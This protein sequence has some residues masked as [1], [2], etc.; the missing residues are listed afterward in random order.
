MPTVSVVI[1]NFNH[2]EFLSQALASVASLDRDD[3][4][5]IEVDDG[6]TD[7]RT[8]IELADL[9]GKGINVIRQENKGCQERRNFGNDGT[10]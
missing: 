2:G 5:L 9:E 8:I 3:I 1:P 4:E 7:E 10:V 6:S